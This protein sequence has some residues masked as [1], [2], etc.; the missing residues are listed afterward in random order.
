[1]DRTQAIACLIAGLC[2][3]GC[4]KSGAL[5]VASKNFTEQ[6]ILGEIMAQHLERRLHQKVDR[7][8][9][10]GGTLL[11]HQALVNGAIDLYPEYTGTALTEILKLPPSSDPAAVIAQVREEYRKRWGI[12]W[13]DPLGFNNTFAMLVRG[14]E[15]RQQNLESLSDA[16]RRGKGWTLGV[17]Y[18]FLQ[19]ADGFTGLMKAYRL[20]LNGSPKSMDLG[21]LYKALEQN[22]VDMI[23]ANFTD[24]LISAQDLKVLRDDKNYFPPYY[25]APVVRGAALSAHSGLREALQ[26]LSGKFP[27]E[28]MRKLNYAV[29]GKHQRVAEV[30]QGFLRDAGLAAK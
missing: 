28:T 4:S 22:Q 7:K 11:A 21:L 3:A 15:A 29:D 19:R 17:G 12:E 20:P 1:M 8:L 18:E 23:A 24:G 26:E 5:V 6:V 16:G 14:Q 25:G 13:I 27:D 9:N 10:L 2:L 30:A